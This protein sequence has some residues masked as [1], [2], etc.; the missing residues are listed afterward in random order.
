MS[1]MEVKTHRLD[2]GPDIIRV[3]AAFKTQCLPLTIGSGAVLMILAPPFFVVIAEAREIFSAL[4]LAAILNYDAVK[5]L[6]C[7]IFVMIAGLTWQTTFFAIKLIN[8]LKEL[9]VPDTK[10]K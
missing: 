7:A 5:T 6:F 3:K 1:K 4:G 10:S 9:Q 8:K 2:R